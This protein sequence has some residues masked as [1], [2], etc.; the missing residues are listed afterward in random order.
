MTPEQEMDFG[1]AVMNVTN[2]PAT[3]TPDQLEGLVRDSK[4]PEVFAAWLRHLD[5]SDETRARL[6]A[7]IRMGMDWIVEP[8]E[9]E[10]AP[11]P[12]PPDV[13]RE[14][15]P[16]QPAAG[17]APSPPAEAAPPPVAPQTAPP[18]EGETWPPPYKQGE[19]KEAYWERTTTPIQRMLIKG[20]GP[21]PGM[22]YR[23]IGHA[24]LQDAL[25]TGQ[26]KSAGKL[27]I[28]P[29]QEGK[30]SFADNPS[31]AL[32]YATNGAHAD[33]R[34][35]PSRPAYV[36]EVERQPSM[37]RNS[38]GELEAAG[39]VPVD[40]IKRVWE[41]RPLE[42][43]QYTSR[44]EFA[45][46]TANWE[47]RAA[48]AVR[49]PA[50]NAE[51]YAQAPS[52]A[53]APEGPAAG[54]PGAP[55]ETGEAQG[56]PPSGT[57]GLKEFFADPTEGV[58][59]QFWQAVESGATKVGGIEEPLL[60]LAKMLRGM[61]ALQSR[62]EFDAMWQDYGENVASL[63]GDAFRQ[64]MREL[65]RRNAPAVPGQ[66]GEAQA[67][68]DVPRE[69]PPEP[70]PPAQ[71]PHE[72]PKP[73]EAPPQDY[74]PNDPRI[75]LA[76]AI[77][78]TLDQ[79][80]EENPVAI[81][82]ET[83]DNLTSGIYGGTMA[84]QGIPSSDIYDALEL[85]VNLWLKKN[86]YRVPNN[87]AVDL[88]AAVETIQELQGLV[89]PVQKLR[90]QTRSENQQFSTPP[91]YAYAVG[92]IAN[93]RPDDVVLEP[94]AG[95]GNLAVQGILGRAKRVHGN[96]WE[97]KR[98]GFLKRLG[99][100]STSQEDAEFIANVVKDPPTV[101][102]MN[103]PFSRSGEIQG[104]R[105]I[106]GMDRRHVESALKALQEGGRL[107]AVMGAPMRGQLDGSKFGA[108]LHDLQGRYNVRANVIL[109]DRAIYQ[110]SGTNFPTRVL[111]VDKTGAT[112]VDPGDNPNTIE[113][114]VDSLEELVTTLEGIRNDRPQIASA[115][116]GGEE[117]AGRGEPGR[118][119]KP[120]TN[121]PTP[122]VGEG[123]GGPDR[124][125]ARPPK[126]D[127]PRPAGEGGVPGEPGGGD[128]GTAGGGRSEGGERGGTGPSE[129]SPGVEG[130]GGAGEPGGGPLPGRPA[131]DW[132]VPDLDPAVQAILDDVGDDLAKLLGKKPKGTP[133]EQSL[134]VEAQP[135]I[136]PNILFAAI[137]VGR[138]LYTAAGVK[139]QGK[140]TDTIVRLFGEA[141]RPYLDLAWPRIHSVQ[142]QED[143]VPENAFEF[144]DVVATQAIPGTKPHPGKLVETAS[145]AAVKSPKVAYQLEL[146]AKAIADG[147]LSDIQSEEATIMAAAMEEHLTEDPRHVY[148]YRRGAANG[149]GTGAGK[150]RVAAAL[151]MDNWRRGRKKLVYFA[152]SRDL[153]IQIK[154]EWREMGGDP[155]DFFD[156]TGWDTPK[157]K[158]GI[159]FVTYQMLATQSQAVQ[160]QTA[161]NHLDQ[162]VSWLGKQED[163]RLGNRNTTAVPSYDGLV[164][165]DEAHLMRNAMS[166]MGKRGAT[167]V[168]KRGM[169]GVF[170]QRRLPDARI[171]YFSATLATEV[172]NIGMA[173]R[174]GLWGAGTEFA[175]S[176]GL[177]AAISGQ[178]L[179]GMEVLARDM[180]AMGVYLAHELS[181]YDKDHPEQT[182][183]QEKIEHSLTPSQRE[184]YD[185]ICNA[186][187][188]IRRGFAHGAGVT[189]QN[190]NRQQQG[191]RNSQFYSTQQRFY[192]SLITAMMTP[193]LIRNVEKDMAEGKS[194]LVQL[195]QTE[196]AA[197]ERAS[198]RQAAEGIPDA[199]FSMSPAQALIDLIQQYYPVQQYR[200]VPGPNNTVV[201]VP[202]VNR[203][204]T[205]Q[206]NKQAVE[207]RE[208]LKDETALAV[209]K[210]G[211]DHSPLDMIIN[212]FGAKNVA[213]VTSRNERI[214]AQEPNGELKREKRPSSN[215]N[216]VD[217][218]REGRKRILIFSEAGGTGA[219]YH[220][221]RRIKNQQ[222]RMHYVLQ[223]GWSAIV[224][225][226]GAGRGHR[227]NQKQAPFIRLMTVAEIP[228]HK[229]FV[230]TAAR[231]LA[232][233][234][235]LTR[236]QSN[237]AS[238]ALFS[239]LD[240]LEST[241]ATDALHA[242]YR[243]LASG[244]RIEIPGGE[245][246]SVQDFQ[247]ATGLKVVDAQGTLVRTLPDMAH[248]L[249]RM[250]A[251]P[252]EMQ[253]A[254][255]NDFWQRTIEIIDHAKLTG[256]Y[257]VGVEEYRAKKIV[258]AHEETVNE[259]PSGATT[260][261]T[262]VRATHAYDMVDWKKLHEKETPRG[263]VYSKQGLRPYAIVEERN[264]MDPATGHVE[265]TYYLFSPMGKKI[266]HNA[267]KLD[268]EINGPEEYQRSW[269]KLTEEEAKTAWAHTVERMQGT[270]DVDLHLITGAI[271][272]V[273]GRVEAGH[274]Q[275]PRVYRMKLA[276][277]E[278]LLGRLIAPD[279]LTQVLGRLG[280]DRQFDLAPAEVIENLKNNRFQYVLD[281]GW[282]L[283]R[284]QV[285]RQIR[286][287]VVGVAASW[288]DTM[289]AQGFAVE[290]VDA[291]MRVFA[292]T[293]NPDPLLWLLSEH[294]ITDE[295][296]PWDRGDATRA[297]EAE[298]EVAPEQPAAPSGP[299]DMPLDVEAKGETEKPISPQDIQAL[300]TKLY[301]VP[302]RSG[303]LRKRT[304]A[305]VYKG[306]PEVVRA[307]KE[308]AQ[309]PPIDSHEFA[310]HLDNRLKIS[311][312]APLDVKKELET[313]DYDPSQ[314]RRDEGFAEFMRFLLT[315]DE[316]PIQAPVTYKW[317]STDWADT[318]PDDAA[319]I[320]QVK[321]LINRYRAQG[322]MQ[323]SRATM[324]DTGKWPKE[325]VTERV[326]N[327]LSKINRAMWDADYPVAR[328]AI[329]ASARKPLGVGQEIYKWKQV[330]TSTGGAFALDALRNGV[331]SLITGRRIGPSLIDVFK[332]GKI[333][334]TQDLV[335]FTHFIR[336]RHSREVWRKP[337]K[338]R[339]PGLA[340]VDADAIYDKFKG[341]PGWLE[342]ART[343][344]DFHNALI[345]MLA[346]AGRMSQ[347]A[348]DQI[349]EFY[350]AYVPLHRLLQ[351]FKGMPRGTKGLGRGT[352]ARP[353]QPAKRMSEKG[354]GLPVLN[355][356]GV[357]MRLAEQMYTAAQSAHLGQMLRQISR[358]R[359]GMGEWY[360][361]VDLPPEIT[362]A[363]L[364]QI[365]Y[366][367][368]Q[369]GAEVG[370]EFG[371]LA[372]RIADLA[373]A[374]K[375]AG[376]DLSKADISA[377]LALATPMK[378]YQGSQPLIVTYEDGKP[379]WGLVNP[380]LFA[381][382]VDL[383]PHVLH[384]Y[385][386]M[387]LGRVT[388]LKRLTTT[389]LVPGF[390]M[391]INP[392]R[393]VK[394][395]ILRSANAKYDPLNLLAPLRLIGTAL[396]EGVDAIGRLLGKEPDPVAALYDA[397][398]V[399]L[400]GFI[401][402]DMSH[403]MSNVRDLL[404]ETR[405]L[406]G[407]LANTA[408][409]P[410][411]FLR[412][413]MG[414]FERTPRLAEFT[415]ILARNGYT[416]ADLKAGKVP[417]PQVVMQ[418]AFAAMNV[419]TNFKRA[420]TI[421]RVANKMNAYLNAKI[422]DVVQDTMLFKEHP[423]RTFLRGAA[424]ITIPSLLLWWQ[425]KDEDWWKQ[426]PAWKRYTGWA[427]RTGPGKDDWIWIP[428]P[429]LLGALFGH[430]PVA[431]LDDAYAQHPKEVGDWFKAVF[432]GPHKRLG[433]LGDEVAGQYGF[434]LETVLPDAV[435]P[436]LEVI[437]NKDF[438]LDR[439][440]ESEGLTSK[441]PG[442]R[443]TRY[444]SELARY[445]GY[446]F[447]L[448]P[449]KLDHLI[450]GYG[451]TLGSTLVNL[452]KPGAV[453]RLLGTARLALD[454]TRGESVEEFYRAKEAFDQE[455]TSRR[456]AVVGEGR[457]S[458]LSLDA[459]RERASRQMPEDMRSQHH[460]YSKVASLMADVRA[461]LPPDANEE[462][463]KVYNRIL[464]GLAVRGLGKEPRADYPD[465]F[466]ATDL[467]PAV[468]EIRDE[469]IKGIAYALT[470]PKPTRERGESAEKFAESQAKRGAE[471]AAA[472]EDTKWAG[473]DF[474]AMEKA[475]RADDRIKK[476]FSAGSAG[477]GRLYRL[478]KHFGK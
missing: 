322:A 218:F 148:K 190:R 412:H 209:A 275:A 335:D 5:L 214:V 193:T 149:D 438:F 267:D 428:S 77:A 24:E 310:H 255:F 154:D 188:E 308:F 26:I 161:R 62:A 272:P 265:R 296:S 172:H 211:V 52:P 46:V 167:G 246:M 355:P 103:P 145:M 53:P 348:A 208:K 259:H 66:E 160:G 249:N 260:K 465:I 366:K 256:T 408:R 302:F 175:D 19:S 312:T 41:V 306:G 113:R 446:Q 333:E 321:A 285:K 253:Q 56:K 419:T 396:R 212:Y 420:G 40:R 349:K 364:A 106:I 313:L 205:P 152:P 115:E 330:Y 361:E 88:K 225:K 455:W 29:G 47:S 104:D 74:D 73:P 258:K 78:D 326:A 44:Y 150:G 347:A 2:D 129:R 143:L 122:P 365:A 389:E 84:E 291:Q 86:G 31:L 447:G 17:E 92:W 325:P 216:E 430:L 251:L 23:G 94:S 363:H 137:K 183:I 307:K 387:T 173:E 178:R 454:A 217:A 15:A 28:G 295:K 440:I 171:A 439:A 48:A 461:A 381:A 448:S 87:E 290:R 32:T 362:Q 18:P 189:N 213:E 99:L 242:F 75:R 157:Q 269:R 124:G 459:A 283:R 287:E 93:L 237:A 221:D 133:G 341:R 67:K 374:L 263:F 241:E 311:D 37:I 146:P 457:K 380:E 403:A 244:R 294:Q 399:Q 60:Q 394:T 401:G 71:K 156:L 424:W 317:F 254:V 109:S 466:T 475:L 197:Q 262:K 207:A 126:A 357:T 227:T 367:L 20:T 245:S 351:A 144:E 281:N 55:R 250:L 264:R 309:S 38:Q 282:Q 284:A 12:P 107:V 271:L 340:L 110:Q 386:S 426:M 158:Q 69:T 277:G 354:S 177:I 350:P 68:P 304:A 441:K 179:V 472:A 257:N 352:A 434:P 187:R 83:L 64:G 338:P 97:P 276:N 51:R 437:V 85:G 371:D 186:W 201:S 195:T 164:I 140:W 462:T 449:V 266:A 327:G 442:D 120:S 27:N 162:I 196:A 181:M 223:P 163:V 127:V 98:L 268:T 90:T 360:E 293:E 478:R 456:D 82:D 445:L 203:D 233:L 467:P 385:L 288:F 274:T 398:G 170:L 337:E 128:T 200:L 279:A 134:A 194:V 402:Q 377:F 346:E 261:Y 21:V 388:R 11:A 473:L 236:G 142:E 273:W 436:A 199:E 58:R 231:R 315:T 132:G 100:T 239:D 369:R 8:K 232:Q 102:L 141:V 72:E 108:W 469:A 59:T 431:V 139:E 422:Q 155:G 345:D 166:V 471:W 298:F 301:G 452:D 111:V 397:W 159:M 406:R 220:A 14:T 418:A 202:V 35:S 270:F 80:D 105:K 176:G 451:G 370:P 378:W 131:R 359:G 280:V 70:K 353:A 1:M 235:A 165:F 184:A 180:K 417:P 151:L 278:M 16:S 390:G 79:G 477:S 57:H 174:L 476:P 112:P 328:F 384:P 117:G 323:R 470:Q 240:N 138:K 423:M 7:G 400:S 292:P 36:L 331:K 243:S 9:A 373:D 395:Y 411:E 319:K 474:E 119:A 206:L 22:A 153:A 404:N 303:F 413:L 344:T 130:S 123:G 329:D 224:F 248:F 114:G 416:S 314:Q 421:G 429:F 300:M 391:I 91:A 63:K 383:S 324:S 45:D 228:S 34:P 433:Q 33:Y 226:Q 168:S 198:Q 182:V 96:E 42:D 382:L 229:R 425:N 464:T 222:Q 49:E 215:R 458:G 25:A 410:V 342:A 450:K 453:E 379:K 343:F 468:A 460:R 13:P 392:L 435:Q 136:D 443:A 39:G 289:T 219:S 65:G 320:R 135:N 356:L 252:I 375:K 76:E 54:T 210:L 192:N 101:V 125:P 43:T 238:G 147:K 81:T 318:H 415:A 334:T 6:D 393:D 4:A 247:D 376:A 414:V 95:T 204:G 185:G 61:G 444:T 432:S 50:P 405:G 427:F 407:K 10:E 368:K 118:G 316:A 336:A 299:F 230:S 121:R 234:G 169:N 297:I 89:L 372:E 191:S 409:H 358:E 463:N 3:L 30:T 116:Q 339:N 305:A 332:A 286:I